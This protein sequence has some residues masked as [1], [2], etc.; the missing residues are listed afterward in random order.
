[1]PFDTAYRWSF[2]VSL[3]L[4]CCCLALAE[5]H[6]FPLF[7]VALPLVM[8]VFVLAWRKE[9]VWVLGESVANYLGIL[10][11]IGAAGWILFYLPQTE[12]E[13]I[14]GGVPWPAGLLPHLGPL[15][16][17]LLVVKL[18]R[19]KALP[20]FWVIQTMGLMMVA[21]GCILASQSYYGVLL[22]LYA[23]SLLWCLSLH[24]AGRERRRAGPDAAGPLFLP[25]TGAMVPWR[26]LGV[27]LAARW[28]LVVA[29]LSFLLFLVTPRSD[30]ARWDPEKLTTGAP[31]RTGRTGVEFGMDLNRVGRI[32]LS[33]ETAFHVSATDAAQQP[34][35]LPEG[36]RWRV[37][38]L[39]H[40]H[41]GR[42]RVWQ[43]LQE[44][45]A[46]KRVLHPSPKVVRADTKLAQANAVHLA[47]EVKPIQT[48]G[49]V[50]AEPVNVL[51]AGFDAHVGPDPAK[52]DLFYDLSGSD[53]LYPFL[54]ATGRKQPHRYRQIIDLAQQ[55]K[56]S[57]SRN[58]AQLYRIDIATQGVPDAVVAW[59]RR[60]LERLPAL[61]DA[62]LEWEED[63][64]LLPRHHEKVARALRDH[65]T[66]S[67]EFRY[68]L[69]LNR[70]DL[71]LDPLVDFLLNT[72]SGHCERYAGALTLALRSLRIPA[73]VV[74][75]Y[76]GAEPV[77]AG[78][79][80]VRQDHAHSW[81][82]VYIERG[83]EKLWLPLDPTPGVDTAAASAVSWADW[84]DDLWTNGRSF[85]KNL[86]VEYNPETQQAILRSL[87]RGLV[88]SSWI[89]KA[90]LG[91]VVL[92]LG[93]VSWRLWRRWRTGGGPRETAAGPAD[94][95]AF[96]QAFL[97]V[98]MKRLKLAPAE[99]Q[100]PLEFASLLAKR[101]HPHAAT[102][103]WAAFPR[104]LA[105]SLYRERFG[106]RPL[107]FD[108]QATLARK[109]SDFGRALASLPRG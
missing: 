72:K 96:Y 17:V 85:W 2:Y 44:N 62:G 28:L 92:A 16:T 50:L 84:I 23:L 59:T 36:I 108:E 38:V 39:D 79:Y 5:M 63:D 54:T 42:W 101:L 7:P 55:D 67:G 65:F 8:G 75:G 32:E 82:E 13:M 66:M 64:S 53:V 77:E 57:P 24:Y 34:V 29:A 35:E 10:I 20:D 11:A 103:T 89:V 70:V 106:C 90:I 46:G 87:W 40:Y 21:L 41:K 97:R 105:E 104:Q 12:E 49:L 27:P 6:F 94:F 86:V 22:L 68:S 26:W 30:S 1:M 60:L 99:C 83:D 88:N 43:Q 80:V 47:F 76:Q 33:T 4:A 18:F 71:S 100:T 45:L 73:R 52:L 58:V 3:G 56:A 19:P 109:I 74:R 51:L 69:D 9:G 78:G 98:V 102:A 31:A 25:A 15:L 95:P 37:D 93:F 61:K 107:S 91:A 14:A 48:G 81:T